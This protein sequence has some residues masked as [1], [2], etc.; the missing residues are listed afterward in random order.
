MLSIMTETHGTG[1]RA[2]SSQQGLLADSP[3][4]CSPFTPFLACTNY[5]TS[6]RYSGFLARPKEQQPTEVDIAKGA[7]AIYQ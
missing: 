6:H 3:Q 1:G 4:P 2:N 5:D 7:W